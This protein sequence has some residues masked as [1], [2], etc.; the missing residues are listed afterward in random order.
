MFPDPFPI[1]MGE[2]IDNCDQSP[3]SFG[4]TRAPMISCESFTSVVLLF[5]ATVSRFSF[6][7]E[8][9]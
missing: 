2:M 5:L 4:S 1:S 6:S 7:K 8:V 9:P 3:G